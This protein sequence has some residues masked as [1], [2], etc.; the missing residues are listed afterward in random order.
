MG[1]QVDL[2]PGTQ[3]RNGLAKKVIHHQQGQLG[4]LDM[5]LDQ[6]GRRY[7]PDQLGCTS[8]KDPEN[9]GGV[10][11]RS[12]AWMVSECFLPRKL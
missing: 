1:P 7:I 6:I 4:A 12:S 9:R 2:D 3:L 11:L 10:D 8:G 5:E